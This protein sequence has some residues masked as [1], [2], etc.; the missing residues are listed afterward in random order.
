MPPFR[1]K[2]EFHS[3]SC[4]GRNFLAERRKLSPKAYKRTITRRFAAAEIP[5][6]AGMGRGSGNRIGGGR[7][8]KRFFWGRFCVIIFAG[9]R[10]RGGDFGNFGGDFYPSGS[11]N[12]D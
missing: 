2:P 8:K 9:V 10:G 4:E 3:H 6:F 1:R 12:E 7:R 11:W 5:A